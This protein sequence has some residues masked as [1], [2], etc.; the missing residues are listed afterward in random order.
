MT[1]RPDLLLET[2]TIGVFDFAFTF[3]RSRVPLGVGAE[4][5]TNSATHAIQALVDLDPLPLVD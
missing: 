4:G 5:K 1:V 2:A 3:A